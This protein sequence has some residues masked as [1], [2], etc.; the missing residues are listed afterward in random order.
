MGVRFDLTTGNVREKGFQNVVFKKN[1]Y[2]I[3]LGSKNL[4]TLLND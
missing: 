2:A 3:Q 4:F 1:G